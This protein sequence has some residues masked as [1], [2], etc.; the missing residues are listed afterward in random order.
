MIYYLVF[1]FAFGIALRFFSEDIFSW[2]IFL[3]CLIIIYFSL[4]FYFRK[5]IY[6]KVFSCVTFI[7]LGIL[8]AD[9]ALLSADNSQMKSFT[10]KKVVIEG[11]VSSEPKI[12]IDGENIEMTVSKVDGKELKSQEETLVNY[13]GYENFSYGDEVSVKGLVAEPESFSTDGARTFN[14]PMYLAKSGIYTVVNNAQVE[15]AGISSGNFL[16][17]FLYKIKNVFIS[18]MKQVMSDGDTALMSGI[19]IGAQDSI[20]KAIKDDFRASGLIHIMVLS[21]Y[22]IT[23]VGEAVSRVANIWL[24][25][26]VSLGF[27]GGAIILF[28]LLSGG[29]A[30][31]IRSTI[32]SLIAILGKILGREY[33]ALRA[34]FVVGFLMIAINPYT[35]LYDP[36]FHLSFLATLGMILLSSPISNKLGFLRFD[37]VK[38][39]VGTTISTQ[40]FVA[41]Y[42]LWSMGSVSI[43]SLLANIL[44][45]P[46]VPMTMFFGF[47]TGLFGFIST[48]LSFIPGFISHLLILYTTSIAHFFAT[49]PFA[50]WRL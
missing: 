28:A 40:I 14:Y 49:L 23:V 41:P 18:K 13:K 19:L 39:I 32:M 37:S 46:T 1:N 20:S 38:D 45:L 25:K 36:S 21:G 3:F 33:D 43:V 42:L 22:N 24:S 6:L 5:E 10:S 8:C 11:F 35:L 48:Y 29:G 15:K 12:S 34:L 9:Y 2:A 17:K 47:V 7:L 30:A 16:L 26:F 31:T 27:G 50:V 44:V 4:W